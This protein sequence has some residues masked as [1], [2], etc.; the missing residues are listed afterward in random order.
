MVPCLKQQIRQ[1]FVKTSGH[2]AFWRCGLLFA[3]IW[4]YISVQWVKVGS[5]QE[6]KW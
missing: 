5:S 2:S 4:Y 1:H 3:A 6:L